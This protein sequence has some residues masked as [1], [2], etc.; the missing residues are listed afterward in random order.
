[1]KKSNTLQT[2]VHNKTIPISAALTVFFMDNF[3]YANPTTLINAKK[4]LDGLK[5]DL[6]IIIP[7]AA[8]VILLCLAIAYAGRYIEK[9]TFIRWAVGVVVAGSAHEL[10]T[11]LF[12]RS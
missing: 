2:I 9:S 4:A 5:G 12:T 10:A 1:M 11:L 3:A 8:G 6:K 7:I